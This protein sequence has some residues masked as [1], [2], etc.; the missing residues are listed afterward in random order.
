MVF[1]ENIFTV[2]LLN[3]NMPTKCNFITVP[4]HLFMALNLTNQQYDEN[5]TILFSCGQTRLLQKVVTGY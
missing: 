3:N 4:A 1:K 5:F 2:T